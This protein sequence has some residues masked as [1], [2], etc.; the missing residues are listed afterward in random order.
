MLILLVFSL[1]TKESYSQLTYVG[2]EKKIAPWII[3][4]LILDIAGLLF[5]KR[6]RYTDISLWFISLSFLFMFG[7][8]FLYAFDLQ[9]TLVWNPGTQYGND[10]KIDSIL[11][12]LYSINL[13][14]C[15]SFLSRSAIQDTGMQTGKGA[16]RFV[17]KVGVLCLIVGVPASLLYS[18]S[19][20][21]VTQ[22]AGSYA[23]Y[24]EASSSGIIDDLSYLLVPGVIYLLCSKTIGKKGNL[25]I[26][27]A[28]CLYYCAIMMLSG[29]RKV[30]L[31]AI[32]AI[33]LCYM[34]QKADGKSGKRLYLVAYALLA[35]L[36][37][38][39]LY[40]IRDNRFDLASIPGKYLESLGSLDFIKTL[41]G[42]TFAETGLTFYSVVNIV[43]TVP[44]VFPF[45]CGMT[46]VRTLVS[47]L[48]IGWLVG[49]FFAQA[50][51][52]QVIN[53]YVNIPAGSSL[54]GD[55]YWNFGAIG[56][57][58]FSFLFGM[59]LAKIYERSKSDPHSK[60]FYFSV[61]Y[62]LLIGV[63]AGVFELYR[64]FI[65]A[66]VLP[67]ILFRY[68]ISKEARS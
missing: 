57:A 58:A 14:F 44:S 2:Y 66:A 68:F 9:T 42:E 34:S 3:L 47:T 52:T 55:F 27:I 56:G 49:D 65:I 64:P 19:I 21:S 62:I 25:L 17:R 33:M 22:A 40:V 11:Y 51:S 12:A 23:A 41:A 7:H 6:V 29:S 18:L 43:K 15:G 28:A 30:A 60:A 8:V 5:V 10:I 26:T 1:W 67:Y 36:L 48:P 20:V 31:F 24:T 37:L 50:S 16:S 39:L 54:I 63:R 61:V 53:S 46:F 32:V 45:E 13:M 4:F 38:D 59:F 35:I